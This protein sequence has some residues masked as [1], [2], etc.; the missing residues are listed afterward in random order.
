MGLLTTGSVTNVNYT[1]KRN[2]LYLSKSMSKFSMVLFSDLLRSLHVNGSAT[3]SIFSYVESSLKDASKFLNIIVGN[4][5]F[6]SSMVWSVWSTLKPRGD[7]KIWEF[8]YLS[9]DPSWNLISKASLNTLLSSV[10]AVYLLRTSSVE[11]VR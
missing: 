2:V 6:T 5:S 8:R 1:H 4:H 7:W 3:I 10:N 9:K 11:N